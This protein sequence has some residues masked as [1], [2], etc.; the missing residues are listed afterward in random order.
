VMKTVYRL[1]SLSIVIPL[2][3]SACNL[4]TVPAPSDAPAATEEPA[5]AADGPGALTPFDLT[6]VEAGT[7]MR[8]YDNGLLVFVPRGEFTM[9]AQSPLLGVE[10]E[11][12]PPHTVRTGDFWIYKTKVTNDMYRLC[13]AAGV[14]SPPADE[15]PLP[16]YLDPEIK[17]HP[18]IGVNWEQAQTYCEWMNAR[19]PTEAEWEKTARGPDGSLYPWGEAQPDCD[20][21]N[22][23]DCQLADTSDVFDHPD[24]M[25]FYEAADMA[26]NAFEWVGDWYQA[27]YYARSPDEDPLGPEMGT[28]RVV[29]GSSYK[30]DATQLPSARRFY[31]QPEKYREDLG[32][33]CVVTTDTTGYAPYCELTARIPGPLWF[34]P[35][36][37][38]GGPDEGAGGDCESEPPALSSTQYCFDQGTQ[39]G[40]ATVTY[41]G[42]LNTW[43]PGC[44]PSASPMGCTGPEN[45]LVE[46][47]ICSSCEESIVETVVDPSCDLGYTLTDGVCVFEGWPPVMGGDC[48]PGWFYDPGTDLCQA[49][50]PLPTSED[51]PDGYSYY[52]AADCCVAAFTEP[53]PDI[54]GVPPHA[55]PGCP[56]GYVYDETIEACVISGA[57]GLRTGLCAT[58]DVPLGNCADPG[59][60]GCTLSLAICQNQ[61]QTYGFDPARCCC[62]NANGG[63]VR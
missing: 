26:G 51:C 32:F 38:S 61:N 58:F 4:P 49:A 63:C 13:V 19:L 56:T 7:T 21:L 42:E 25:S 11:D 43:D 31:L 15:P 3:L 34:E 39:T 55:Y 30:S 17:D 10:S 48:P 24:G 6:G 44:I 12:N 1:L 14:C 62:T 8:W 45:T 54:P 5:A 2:V 41:T 47:E 27:N 53:S 37:P 59:D 22:F 40:G 23:E 20:L 28:A 16:D 52:E 33:R 60:N 57:D 29:R 46:V 35:F 18:V 36:P 50:L 9:G